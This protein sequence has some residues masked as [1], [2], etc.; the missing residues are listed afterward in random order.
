M[1]VSFKE[2]LGALGQI[3][4]ATHGKFQEQILG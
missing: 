3:Q 4:H 2:D 1:E